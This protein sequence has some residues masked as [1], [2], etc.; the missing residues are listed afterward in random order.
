MTWMC[1][2][3]DGNGIERMGKEPD[4]PPEWIQAVS[5]SIPSTTKLCEECGE[6]ISGVCCP[7]RL[8]KALENP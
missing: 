3:P 2:M 8:A 5:D 1:P 6:V 7:N 4:F